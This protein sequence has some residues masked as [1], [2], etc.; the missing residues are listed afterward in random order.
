MH[1]GDGIADEQAVKDRTDDLLLLCRNNL[2]DPP[3]FHAF[4]RDCRDRALHAR[5]YE[6]RDGL[7]PR[8]N[9]RRP[10][11]PQ[12]SRK[13]GRCAEENEQAYECTH[14]PRKYRRGMPPT[15]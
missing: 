4:R 13:D 6:R 11:H 2:R 10:I 14:P 9:C 15:H 12:L 7:C 3:P 1:S 8:H 5:T